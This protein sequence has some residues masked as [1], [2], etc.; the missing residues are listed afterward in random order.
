MNVPFL[1]SEALKAL[2]GIRHGFF[3]RHGGTSEGLFSSLNCAHGTGD[4]HA[5]VEENFRRI[6]GALRVRENHVLK[7]RQVHG[8]EVATAT[9]PWA[10]E[11]R[12][13]ADAIVTTIPGL[14]IGITT[15]DCV[16]VLFADAENRVIATAHAGWKGALAGI[17]EATLA[18]MEALGARREHITAAI[19]PAI[20]QAS[21]EVDDAFYQGFKAESVENTRFFIPSHRPQHH[22]F[23]LPGYVEAKLR[24]SGISRV[25]LLARDT[26]L[27]ENTFFSYRRATLRGEKFYGCQ[28][29]AIV[30]D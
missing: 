7:C 2:P 3:T 21:Y 19:G 20:Q 8:V 18:A 5:R 25:N 16:P 15:A 10:L 12:P 30:M 11:S 26:A 23:D 1:E 22:R 17:L 27:E 24:A 13:K 28:L 29:S 6:A 9:A 14:A 4:D